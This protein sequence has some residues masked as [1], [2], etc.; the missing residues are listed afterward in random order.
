MKL[1]KLATTDGKAE[2]FDSYSFQFIDMKS[3]NWTTQS[4]VKSDIF[5]ITFTHYSD[6]SEPPSDTKVKV[7]G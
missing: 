5:P 3:R 4:R 7:L 1:G 2:I 6:I